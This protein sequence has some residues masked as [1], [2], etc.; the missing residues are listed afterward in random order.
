[1]K[2]STT[3]SPAAEHG[4][5]KAIDA[6]RS[7]WLGVSAIVF[8]A[9]LVFLT[10]GP[11][12]F[13]HFFD[14]DEAGLMAESWAMTKGQHLYADIPQIHPVLNFA[15]MVPFF[16]FLP[17]EWVSFAIKTMNLVLVFLGALLS[18]RIAFEWFRSHVLG[19]LAASLFIFY[20]S[21]AWAWSA[22]GEFYAMFPVLLS[23]WLLF[24]VRYP[25]GLISYLVGALWAVA[26]FLKQVAAFDALGL[27]LAYLTLD[28][29]PRLGKTS[30]TG[31]LGLGFITVT[32]VIGAWLFAQGTLTAAWSSIFVHPLLHYTRPEGAYA[33]FLPELTRTLSTQMSLSLP[34]ILGIPFL[35]AAQR[36]S[37]AIRPEGA[38]F[39]IVVLIWLG[40]DLIG[41][42]ASGRFYPHYLLQ[43]VPAASLLPLFVL[44]R[45]ETWAPRT[46]LLAT[47]G[48]LAALAL[49]AVFRFV[50]VTHLVAPGN[51]APPQIEQSSA[52]AEFIKTHTRKRSVAVAEFIRT[53][54][55]ENDRIF[56]YK[57]DNLDIFFLS[58]RLSNNGVY[59]FV[60]MLSEHM[61]DQR[62]S[63]RLRKTFLE[64]LPA[65][66]IVDPNYDTRG[67]ARDE[68]RGAKSLGF[69][70]DV[71][72][73]HYA[74][75]T[76]VEGLEVWLRTSP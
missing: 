40:A 11:G 75:S 38:A 52:A 62:E 55:R 1:M 8:L 76:T 59:M 32:V 49:A 14:W 2:F 53:H 19:M 36:K 25:A 45:V 33:S 74:R 24:F 5:H 26:F 3:C 64:T 65:L 67:E 20:C 10:R 57:T 54:T 17:L 30:T 71:L 58:Q 41:L 31:G 27:Y 68:I 69:F 12:L 9:I 6:N 15:V 22:H 42:G 50:D 4:Q 43:L 44:R 7:P 39:F 63:E 16:Y 72:R 46:L 61:R 28:R 13:F 47:R 56:L 34:G 21:N 48:V 37:P 66:I 60:D 35:I 29:E 70:E 23:V 73:S 51:W 18:A